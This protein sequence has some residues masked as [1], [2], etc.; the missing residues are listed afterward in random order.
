MRGLVGDSVVLDIIAVLVMGS[1]RL[2][3]TASWCSI[4]TESSGFVRRGSIMSSREAVE[5]EADVASLL[6]DVG[7]GSRTVSAGR[8]VWPSMTRLTRFRRG[9]VAVCWRRADFLVGVEARFGFL[10]ASVSSPA[11]AP[12]MAVCSRRALGGLSASVA[13]SGM[14]A[15]GASGLC[16]RGFFSGLAGVSLASSSGRKTGVTRPYS[17]FSRFCTR[18]CLVRLAFSSASTVGAGATLSAGWS[19]PARGSSLHSMER[20][21]ANSC[22][23]ISILSPLSGEVQVYLLL[24][25]GE[26]VLARLDVCGNVLLELLPP[27]LD[28]A[29]QG[30]QLVFAQARDLGLCA[31]HRAERPAAAVTL[32]GSGASDD[33]RAGYG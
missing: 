7:A 33:G 13:C 14:A 10:D 26:L 24:V 29:G 15:M 6:G 5:L 32:A 30:V 11:V 31:Q 17:S 22:G 21:C 27:Q 20:C 23:H 4:C 12:S 18:E 28:A 19:S 8:T 3:C 16:W 25:A 1:G 9:F 2:W